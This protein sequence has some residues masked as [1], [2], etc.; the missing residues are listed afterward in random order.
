[1]R[2]LK[3][4][5]SG[6]G[7][8][9]PFQAGAVWALAA[10][11]Y[12]FTHVAGVSGGSIIAAALGFGYKPGEELNQMILDNL[13]SWRFWDLSMNPFSS[14]GL[15]VGRKLRKK[16]IDA[17]DDQPLSSCEIPTNIFAVCIDDVNAFGERPFTVFND[18]DTPDVKIADAVRASISIPGVFTPFKIDGKKYID[19]GVCANFPLDFYGSGKGVVGIKMF[20]GGPRKPPTSFLSYGGSIIN[21]MM[22]SSDQEHIE[23]AMFARVVKLKTNEPFFDLNTTK[24]EALLMIERGFEQTAAQLKGLNL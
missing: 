5:L 6:S 22:E 8:M 18:S 16:M 9:F 12:R 15:V 3:L 11:G 4:V 14:W 19:G 10:N 1:M 13:P 7:T 21:L 20:S 2:D 23:D 17:F 24:D